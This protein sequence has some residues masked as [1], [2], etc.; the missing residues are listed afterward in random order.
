MNLAHKR[1][2]KEAV[3]FYLAYLVLIAL[4]AMLLGGVSGFI[5]PNASYQAGFNMG[6]FL[7]VI[8]VLVLS[9]TIL[10]KKRLLGNFGLILV[11][12]LSGILALF[13]G[14]LLG[15]IPAAFLSTR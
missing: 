2:L 7:A 9:F 14:G 15:L 8:A 10:T 11:A 5:F 4:A 6:N 13:G 12:L 1:S 3:G